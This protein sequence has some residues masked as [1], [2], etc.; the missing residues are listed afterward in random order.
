MIGY[1]SLNL[2]SS[3]CCAIAYLLKEYAHNEGSPYQSCEH[4]YIPPRVKLQQADK[5]AIEQVIDTGRLHQAGFSIQTFF[6][7]TIAPRP[8]MAATRWTGL[9]YACCPARLPFR[10]LN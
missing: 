10:V 2:S 7:L 4:R 6:V 9:L 1:R 8:A 3:R 5:P